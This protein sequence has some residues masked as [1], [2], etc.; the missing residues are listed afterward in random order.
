[1]VAQCLQV[2]INYVGDLC[3][4]AFMQICSHFIR[5]EYFN[6]LYTGIANY[7]LSYFNKF[8][9]HRH[10]QSQK[11]KTT[12]NLL[13]EVICNFLLKRAVIFILY[14]AVKYCKYK[15]PPWTLSLF[16]LQGAR[17]IDAR[18]LKLS[19][20]SAVSPILT[21]CSQYTSHS[22]YS[23]TQFQ[24]PFTGKIKGP[25]TGESERSREDWE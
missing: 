17:G 8:G 12:K 1:M 2:R 22:T 24:C 20:A 11:S 18:F 5:E 7:Y 16:L 6:R 4:T 19:P 14:T 10:G 21:K 15:T 13:L 9:E 3:P 23:T 25:L